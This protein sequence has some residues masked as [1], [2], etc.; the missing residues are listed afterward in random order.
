VAVK[1]LASLFDLICSQSA[2]RKTLASK[3]S[4]I[5]TEWP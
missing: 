3:I 5:A 4:E 2:D 1:Y